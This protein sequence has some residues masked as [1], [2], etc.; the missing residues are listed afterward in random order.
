MAIEDVVCLHGEIEPLGFHPYVLESDGTILAE[1]LSGAVVCFVVVRRS[2][3]LL[4]AVPKGV[5]PDDVLEAA[6][7]AGPEDLIGPS[8]YHELPGAALDWNSP[9]AEPATPAPQVEV[10]LVEF[11][12][13]VVACLK[14]PDSLDL[15]G[16]ISFG[17]DDSLVLEPNALADAAL[18]WISSQDLPGRVTFYSADEEVPETPKADH[19]D[20]PPTTPSARTRRTAPGSTGERGQKPKKKA[21]VASLADSV[22]K[23]TEALPLMMQRLEE[24]HQ[25]TAAMEAASGS[26]R[27]SALKQP[28]GGFHTSGFAKA[29]P[30]D[31]GS[32]VRGMPPPKST[33]QPSRSAAPHVKFAQH[34]T[35]EL[36]QEVGLT[37]SS[38]LAKAV[39]EQSR[40]LTALV[41][42]IASSSMD[43]LQ[44]LASSSTTVG[45]R[46]AS[47]R[48]KLQQELA[49]HSGSFHRSVMTAMAR[50][51]Q[52]AQQAD[53]PLQVL[54]DRGV[55]VT[56]YLERFG[57]YGRVKECGPSLAVRF[58]DGLSSRGELA[59]CEG[60]SGT[61]S[62]VPRTDGLGSGQTGIGPS[63]DTCRRAPAVSLLEQGDVTRKS[64]SGIR[65]PCR[66]EV[67]DNCPP[68][69]QRA[70]H[71][72]RSQRR[73]D[74][75][76]RQGQEQRR[77]ARQPK[78][79]SPAEEERSE[80]GRKAARQRQGRGG[81]RVSSGFVGLD[82]QE[83]LQVK[84]PFRS[85]AAALPRWI[86]STR[87][88][89]AS[90]LA[91]TLHAQPSCLEASSA[92]FWTFC[93]IGPQA[94]QMQVV[95]FGQE[96]SQASASRRSE[97]P[98]LWT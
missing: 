6:Q 18:N 77:S 58:G 78:S 76:G 92:S 4:I 53:A 73:R 85:F 42:Q 25:R 37:E 64:S 57:G 5:L 98:A 70:G 82:P 14:E 17:M 15:A 22:E 9:F 23:V 39:L 1:E 50:R 81:G 60:L 47:G 62:S 59:S 24:L 3:G 44:D 33:S 45:S 96:A 28:L 2:R 19:P 56:R 12:S 49:Q 71:H 55:T 66:P 30:T 21:T 13:E 29:S 68:I 46:G 69:L 7:L 97:L 65:T 83:S 63:L 10:V 72:Q 80:G 54:R 75:L 38:D 48:A 20:S 52:P 94:S 51:M 40:A 35:K 95:D 67:G 32:L 8:T 61:P 89:F 79:K 26:G 87:T 27:P 88:Q 74:S 34:E 41:G 11:S 43:P 91:R 93:W 36:E 84:F 16:I 86:L 31:L 90:F